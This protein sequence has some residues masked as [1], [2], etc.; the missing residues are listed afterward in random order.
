MPKLTR[1]V[2]TQRQIHRTKMSIG[3][4]VL[5]TAVNT[6]TTQAANYTWMTEGFDKR[7]I[8]NFKRGQIVEFTNKEDF[9]SS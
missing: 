5:L 6:L 7:S 1:G 3:L 9:C 2:L 8:V 4:F